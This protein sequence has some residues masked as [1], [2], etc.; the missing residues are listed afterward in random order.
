MTFATQDKLD[1]A[2]AA[3]RSGDRTTARKLLQEV[4][5]EDNRNERAWL[6]LASV[7]DSPE[8]KRKCLK[9]VLQINPENTTAR[10]GLRQLN[11]N[12]PTQEPTRTGFNIPLDRDTLITLGIIA[13]VVVSIGMLVL[14]INNAI[15]SS[16]FVQEGD[17]SPFEVSQ[18]M[19]Q[20]AAAGASPTTTLTPTDGPT[21][22]LPALFVTLSAPTLPPTFTPLPSPTPTDTPTP[23]PTDVP[24]TTYQLTYVGLDIDTGERSLF[25]I[26][27]TGASE[28]ALGNIGTVYDLS[29]DGRIAYV[30]TTDTGDASILVGSASTPDTATALELADFALDGIL[31]LAW[32][33]DGTQ[34]AAI[35]EENAQ[36]VLVNVETGVVTI[37]PFTDV[38]LGRKRDLAWSP[39]GA[40]L[41]FAADTGDTGFTEIYAYVLA[42]ERVVSYTDNIGSSYGPAWS[43]DGTTIAF[44][45]DRN[46]DSDIFLMDADGTAPRLLTSSD[47]TSEDQTPSWSPD[48]R[49]IAFASTRDDTNFQI[50]LIDPQ[51]GAD[52]RAVT[53]N[54]RT[55][56]A[57]VFIP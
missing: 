10:E 44:I 30:G 7:S 5:L 15:R 48:G 19:T 38:V 54:E 3:A 53:A 24:L 25:R 55:A 37:L 36:V 27:A 33:P 57:P 28:I 46:G 51:N 49:W 2:I 31:A 23:L 40:R 12:L 13:A 11:S 6:W 9:R 18:R 43:P 34:I 39:D 21:P 42:D 47:G 26:N 41:L 14:V 22:T 1:R 50:Y 17:L 45:S 8:D 52:V 56:S 16:V 29:T 20:T 35:V 32:S 4:V